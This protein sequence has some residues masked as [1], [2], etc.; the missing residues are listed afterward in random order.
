MEDEQPIG[1]RGKPGAVQ[2]E[3]SGGGRV[4]ERHLAGAVLSLL[5]AGVLGASLPYTHGGLGVTLTVT[6]VC[7][8]LAGAVRSLLKA[9][10]AESPR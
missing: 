2:R 6:G 7:L 8:S 5:T 9:R 10:K 4:R 1:Y 3:E